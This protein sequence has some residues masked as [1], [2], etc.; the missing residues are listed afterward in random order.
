MTT[1]KGR[2]QISTT[3][4]CL[5]TIWLSTVD[6]SKI[7][8]KNSKRSKIR[9]P[10]GK[11]KTLASWTISKMA[12]SI[13]SIAKSK[14]SWKRATHHLSEPASSSVTAHPESV[15]TMNKTTMRVSHCR[16]RQKNRFSRNRS[17][18]KNHISF[19][20]MK[21][22]K[23]KQ[24]KESRRERKNFWITPKTIMNPIKNWKILLSHC[25]IRSNWMRSLGML[26]FGLS[27]TAIHKKMRRSRRCSLRSPWKRS[28]TSLR[29]GSLK[30][31]H[32]SQLKD[33]THLFRCWS[34]S[35]GNHKVTGM[36]SSTRNSTKTHSRTKASQKG[37]ST[38]RRKATL[39]WGIW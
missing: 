37:R 21:I 33:M 3:E 36:I 20:W 6:P 28:E 19:F 27:I 4:A 15:R 25:A 35:T 5:K 22:W 1:P 24:M 29:L 14:S 32:S 26:K 16:S 2:S 30:T 17:Q 38:C 31:T 18:P 39:T 13:A 34:V 7:S 10:S 12:H 23:D 8:G 11:R 9:K